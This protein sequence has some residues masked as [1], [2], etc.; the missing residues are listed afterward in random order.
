MNLELTRARDPRPHDLLVPIFRDR[1]PFPVDC[2]RVSMAWASYIN[3]IRF[4][5]HLVL[6]FVQTHFSEWVR[7]A[8]LLFRVKPDSHHLVS[9]F[10]SFPACQTLPQSQHN[11]VKHLQLCLHPWKQDVKL[12][13]YVFQINPNQNIAGILSLYRVKTAV[14]TTVE[15]DFF[16]P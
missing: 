12:S 13:L 7:V 1:T 6:Q 15:I 4:F 14:C 11:W 9:L 3:M 10:P 2:V 8:L 5:S 16:M